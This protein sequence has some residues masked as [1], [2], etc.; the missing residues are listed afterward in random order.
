[1]FVRLFRQLQLQCILWRSP[2]NMLSYVLRC[3][4]HLLVSSR[5]LAVSKQVPRLRLQHLSQWQPDLRNI[6]VNMFLSRCKSFFWSYQL[7]YS[8]LTF[9]SASGLN[10]MTLFVQQAVQNLDM[11]L[12]WSFDFTTCCRFAVDFWFV[13]DMCRSMLCCGMLC[14]SMLCCSVLYN[15]Q[16]TGWC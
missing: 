12:L 3:C 1:M 8:F 9:R 13:L 10:T 14:C 7:T 6:A 2:W 11:N 16:T 4:R 15:V 5:H